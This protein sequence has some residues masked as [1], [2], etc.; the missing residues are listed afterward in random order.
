MYAARRLGGSAPDGLVTDGLVTGGLAAG[1][2]P[3][4]PGLPLSPDEHATTAA[5][6]SSQSRAPTMGR[7]S[8]LIVP[9]PTIFC[10][11]RPRMEAL[12]YHTHAPAAPASK[13]SERGTLAAMAS[14]PLLEEKLTACLGAYQGPSTQQSL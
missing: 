11:A 10:P 6:P 1:R 4:K 3:G 2:V 5:S 14:A 13:E 8:R 9:P 12:R 7:Q